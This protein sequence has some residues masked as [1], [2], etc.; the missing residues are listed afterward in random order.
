ML[1]NGDDCFPIKFYLLKKGHQ[2]W[3]IS[4]NF[5]T[6]VLAETSGDGGWAAELL[7][8]LVKIR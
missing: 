7:V 8:Q 4:H 3:N 5:P 1:T 6:P 2:I